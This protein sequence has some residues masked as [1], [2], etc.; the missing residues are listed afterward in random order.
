MRYYTDDEIR[1][2]LIERKRK[3]RK[4]DRIIGIISFIIIGS[5]IA[6]YLCYQISSFINWVM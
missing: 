2:M 6:Y 3:A 1:G 5:G 4:T